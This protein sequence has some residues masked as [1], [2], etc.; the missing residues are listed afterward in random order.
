METKQKSLISNLRRLTIVP[1][2]CLGLSVLI[3]SGYFVYS[4]TTAETRQGL[5]NLAHVFRELV[6]QRGSGDFTLEGG[7]LYRGGTPFCTDNSVVDRINQVSGVDATIFYGDTRR[8]TSIRT[9]DGARAVGTQAAPKVVRA[10]LEEGRDYYAQKVL[11]SGT[12]YFGYYVPLRNSDASIVGMVFVGMAHHLVV[13]VI[14]RTVLLIFLVVAVVSGVSMAFSMV[15]A[16]RIIYSLNKTKE[17]L[18]AVAQ[19]GV[20]AK[21]DPYILSRNDEIGEMGRFAVILQKSITELVGTDALTGLYNRRSCGVILT[22]TM[23]EFEKYHT[24][25][26]LA[27]GDI[28]DFKAV[29]DRYGHQAGDAVLKELAHL[30]MEHMGRKGFV[31][32]WGG[33]EFLFIYERIEKQ[34]AIT[35]LEELLNTVRTEHVTY[36]EQGIPVTMTFGVAEYRAGLDIDAVLKN[37]DDN[38][39]YGKVHGKD[40]VVGAEDAPENPAVRYCNC[41]TT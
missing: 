27:I 3:I 17:F 41:E 37:A 2:L 32:R 35:Y 31:S 23:R 18:G 28:D 14:L 12:P 16:K 34:R 8:L 40:R 6:L 10:V 20:E 33:E 36:G 22:N 9:G 15:Y 1:L 24:P 39:Y 21:I 38:L 25:Y 29:N 4:S 30:F 26:V 19:G 7:I 5:D 13:Q 11:V